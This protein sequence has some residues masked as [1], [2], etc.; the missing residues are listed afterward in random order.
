MSK[1]RTSKSTRGVARP[2]RPHPHYRS[3]PRGTTVRTT[4]GKGQYRG[5]PVLTKRKTPRIP[6][7]IGKAIGASTR[8]VVRK[9]PSGPRSFPT[10]TGRVAGR[11][12]RSRKPSRPT[13]SFPT[14]S[15]PR[16]TKA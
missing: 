16:P 1:G 4:P 9:A 7:A 5:H 10:R 15:G 14:R 6:M 2:R 8:Q 11:A 12:I 13:R 3:G